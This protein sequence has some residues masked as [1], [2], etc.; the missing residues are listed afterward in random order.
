MLSESDRESSTARGRE[1]HEHESAAAA[2]P[3]SCSSATLFAGQHGH[4]VFESN[5]WERRRSNGSCPWVCVCLCV[6]CAIVFSVGQIG[7]W[8]LLL[9]LAR[10]LL[11]SLPLSASPLPL[12]AF[13]A[14][15]G[16]FFFVFVSP[17]FFVFA[18]DS[19]AF[20]GINARCLPHKCKHTHT[21][22]YTHAKRHTHIDIQWRVRKVVDIVFYFLFEVIN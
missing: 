21:Q 9:A 22:R 2:R 14:L 8:L 11:L 10:W 15:F 5:N 20:G 19:A 6:V 4:L 1:K 13:C 16:L 7:N 17:P 18:A 3:H 12:Y